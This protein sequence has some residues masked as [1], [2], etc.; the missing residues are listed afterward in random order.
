MGWK[1]APGNMS[2]EIAYFQPEIMERFQKQLMEEKKGPLTHVGSTQGFFP[3]KV[4]VHG[5]QILHKL[6]NG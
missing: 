4:R 1:L 3:Y 2:L 5:T 6:T